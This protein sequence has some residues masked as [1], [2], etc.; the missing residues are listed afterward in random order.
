MSSIDNPL[1][2]NG[3]AMNGCS[4][5]PDELDLSLSPVWKILGKQFLI[6]AR[7]AL[8]SRD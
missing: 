8:K 2:G 1:D 6:L 4:N 7:K 3:L 5:G